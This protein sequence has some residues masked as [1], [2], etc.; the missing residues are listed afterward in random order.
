MSDLS[1]LREPTRQDRAAIVVILVRLL[2]GLARSFWPVLVIA[3]LGRGGG[4]DEAAAESARPDRFE[5]WF[6]WLGIVG[7][8][9]GAVMSIISYFRFYYFVE[10]DEFVIRKG[11]FKKTRKNVSFDRI[12]TINFKQT[13]IHRLLNVVGVEIDTAG[14]RGSEFMIDAVKM[15]QAEAIRDYLIRRREAARAEAAAERTEAGVPP[16]ET[17][18]PAPVRPDELLLKLDP[19]DL[20]RV[21]I[22]QNHLRTAFI[23]IGFFFGIYFNVRDAIG[24]NLE[25]RVF[26]ELTKSGGPQT[27]WLDWLPFVG[28]LL[29][30]AFFLTLIRTVIRYYGLK[31]WQ[32]E[33]GFKLVSGLFSRQEV[34]AVLRKIQVVEWLRNPIRRALGMYTVR[35]KQAASVAIGKQTS[36]NVPGCYA[37]QLDR[38]RAAYFPHERELAWTAFKPNRA[39]VWRRTL[40]LWTPPALALFA[41]N[42]WGYG[43]GW[44][45][46]LFLLLIPLGLL[47]NVLLYRKWH[48]EVSIDGLRIQRGAL[49]EKATL[50]RWRKVQSVALKQSPYQRRHDLADVVLYTAAGSTK[51][52]FIE[53]I[54]A[55]SIANW[56]L[57]RVESDGEKWM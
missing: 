18:S 32:T 13:P 36:I 57:Y 26:D 5:G 22:S 45:S 33:R 2:V 19:G 21:G 42:F 55:R 17:P 27:T 44:A 20:V 47:W 14:S 16:T 39:I 3:L 34:S 28:L 54:H 53:G 23:I 15:D 46:L 35:L 7:G 8:V 52:A 1:F 38:V 51:I 31:L 11:V 12:Q 25:E 56:V 29:V 37:A 49:G 24:I 40:Y 30:A 10:G 41:L 48:Y 4:D 9:Y 6:L 50:L 43:N